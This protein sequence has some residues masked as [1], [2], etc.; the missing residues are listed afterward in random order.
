MN[1]IEPEDLAVFRPGLNTDQAELVIAGVSRQVAVALG[2][3]LGLGYWSGIAKVSS[4]GGKHLRLPRYPIVEVTSVSLGDEDIVDWER[5]PDGDRWG[6]LRHLQRWPSGSAQV[7]LTGDLLRTG[8]LVEVEYSAG[9][10]LPGQSGTAS[11]LPGDIKMAAIELCL[12]KLGRGISE[13]SGKH[14]S[15]E[16]LGAMSIRYGAITAQTSA[17]TAEQRILEGLASVYR[18]PWCP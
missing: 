8:L 13:L 14:V 9:W 3:P 12:N 5:Y 2:Q 16:R 1:L 18:R 7:P 4:E 17:H 15:E 10:K 11:P 6:V